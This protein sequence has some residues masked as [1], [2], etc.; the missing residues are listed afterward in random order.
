MSMRRFLRTLLAP[1]LLLAPLYGWDCGRTEKTAADETESVVI[2]RTNQGDITLRFYPAAAPEHVK[3]FLAHSQSGLYKGCLFHRVIP[4]FMIQGGDP[5]TKDG[6]PANDGAGGYSYRG[7]G[8]RLTAEF[9]N[10][11]HTRG[12]LAMARSDDP[13]SAGSQFFICQSDAPFLDGKYT[14]FGEVIGGLDAVDRIAAAPCGDGNRP[15]EDQRIEEVLIEKWPAR[16]IE[17]AKAAMAAEAVGKDDPG[18][19]EDSV[20]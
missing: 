6:D 2:L 20:R 10:R 17:E 19:S 5:N 3:N 12:T 7:P 11:P 1:V 14:V 9:N 13:N 8:S 18:A 15:L 16:R 4:G